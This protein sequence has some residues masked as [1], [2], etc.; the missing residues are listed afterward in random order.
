MA[1]TAG[2]IRLYACVRYWP[3]RGVGWLFKS[4]VCYDKYGCFDLHPNLLVQFP[5]E[6]SK[7]GTSFLLFTRKNSRT[8][9][10]I[11]DSDVNKLRDSF[12]E[13]SRR[14]IFLIHGFTGKVQL[15]LILKLI[16]LNIYY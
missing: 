2:V 7:L 6:P 15:L 9:K 13:I 12:F 14:T 5:Q 4:E 8:A 10:I 1:A 11:D 3:Y 16:K